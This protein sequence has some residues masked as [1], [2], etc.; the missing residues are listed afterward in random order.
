M[1]IYDHTTHKSTGEELPL[2]QYKGKTLLIVNTATECGLTPQ[3]KGLE[4]LHEKY[5]K[6][7]LQIVGFPCNQFAG[8]EPLQDAEMAQT[9]ELNYGVTFPLTK[10]VKV[11]GK[12]ADP[13]FKYLK[14]ALPGTLGN[15]VKWNFTKFLIG[16]D[17][18]PIKRYAPTTK[19]EE[20]ETDIVANLPV[21]QEK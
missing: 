21:G 13:I 16:P 11:N 19:P 7:G 2:E 10:K 17:G 1:I 18:A 15:A 12:E 9:C 5:G 20:I 14:K 4:A 3:F 8:Q 6:D